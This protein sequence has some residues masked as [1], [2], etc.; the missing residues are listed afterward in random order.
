MVYR[1]ALTQGQLAG[2]LLALRQRRVNDVLL[3]DTHLI[4]DKLRNHRDMAGVLKLALLPDQQRT[5]DRRTAGAVG[6][7]CSGRILSLTTSRRKRREKIS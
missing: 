4:A 1:P 7:A 2:P 6:E 3:G 5:G